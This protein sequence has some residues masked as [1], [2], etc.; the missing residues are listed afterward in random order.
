MAS[1]RKDS[2]NRGTV[3]DALGGNAIRFEDM[4]F[5]PKRKMPQLLCQSA[6]SILLLRRETNYATNERLAWLL[7]PGPPIHFVVACH[8]SRGP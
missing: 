4:R 2:I 5:T 8:Y 1:A 7:L 6:V 3:A